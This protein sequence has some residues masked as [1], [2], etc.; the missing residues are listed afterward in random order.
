MGQ[1]P[2]FQAS[3]LVSAPGRA[4]I[5]TRTSTGPGRVP[6]AIEA[7]PLLAQRLNERSLAR[8]HGEPPHPTEPFAHLADTQTEEELLQPTW[9]DYAW[10]A[11]VCGLG[12][13]VL[14]LAGRLIAT[15]AER[16]LERL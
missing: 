16:A 15:V 13:Y 4:R 12:G 1:S 7:S 6:L 2:L 10:I 9:A 5:D 11:G 14:Y 8:Q 3:A